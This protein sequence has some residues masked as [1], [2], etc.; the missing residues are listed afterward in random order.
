MV[1]FQLIESKGSVGTYLYYPEG[2]LSKNPGTL[3]VD[4][5]K[6]SG[7]IIALAE[8]E[9]IQ[10]HSADSMNR[11]ADVINEMKSQNG[12]TDFIEHVTEDEEEAVYAGF[13]LRQILRSY[14]NRE[15]PQNGKNMW[16]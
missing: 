14:Q 4:F 16:Y 15:I 6:Q 10:K 11:M 2:D 3:V 12:E 5:E 8:S 1:T 9:I 7:E 13:A